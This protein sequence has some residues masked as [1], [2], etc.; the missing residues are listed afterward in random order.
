MERKASGRYSI[1]YKVAED[2]LATLSELVLRIQATGNRA[3]AD[4]LVAKYA[5]VPS[6]IKSDIVNLELEKIP[7][8]I[9]LTYE[10]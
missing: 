1:N 8:D 10:R 7:V 2:A 6:T 9:R 5:M 4:D 3:A